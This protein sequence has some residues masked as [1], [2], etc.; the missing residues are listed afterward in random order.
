MPKK[1]LQKALGLMSG[2]S[3][4]GV[5][6]AVTR[7]PRGGPRRQSELLASAFRPYADSLRRRVLGAQ[8]GT[9]P[10]RDLFAIHVEVAEVAAV[11]I[12]REKYSA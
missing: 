4:D 9:L 2:T 7:I 12:G 5:D 11:V 10:M 3:A 1:V 6:A 8:E